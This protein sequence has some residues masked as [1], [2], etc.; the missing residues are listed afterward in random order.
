MKNTDDTTETSGTRPH[1]L[2]RRPDRVGGGVRG[3]RDHAVGEAE[4]D[5]HRAEVGHVDDDVAG[6]LEVDALVLAPLVVLRGE[7]LAQL[8]VDAG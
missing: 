8:R 7:P 4:L 1:D 5:H 3:A 6:A 2:E